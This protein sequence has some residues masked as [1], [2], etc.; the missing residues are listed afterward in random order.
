MSWFCPFL[1]KLLHCK[2]TVDAVSRGYE[3]SFPLLEVEVSDKPSLS[4]TGA[5]WTEGS[6][7]D[8]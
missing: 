6:S 2:M 3:R 7:R 1:Q 8:Q 5:E 4:C